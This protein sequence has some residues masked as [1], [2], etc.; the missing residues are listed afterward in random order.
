MRSAGGRE[1][2]ER[3]ASRF[4][5]KKGAAKLELEAKLETYATATE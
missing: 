1:K 3:E 4:P 5:C 2:V